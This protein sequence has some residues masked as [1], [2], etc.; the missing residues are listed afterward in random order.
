M[1]LLNVNT[2]PDEWN[3]STGADMFA[4]MRGQGITPRSEPHLFYLALELLGLNRV[5]TGCLIPNASSKRSTG[6]TAGFQYE[7]ISREPGVN[8]QDEFEAE[9]IRHFKKDW[10]ALY[11]AAQIRVIY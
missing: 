3:G 10:L 5:A 11:D 7:G 8:E 6:K 1:I 4:H 2:R 9:Y